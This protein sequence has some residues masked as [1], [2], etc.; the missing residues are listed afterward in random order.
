MHYWRTD[1]FDKLSDLQS[2]LAREEALHFYREY[3]RFL[4]QGLR[5]L[6]L[7]QIEPLLGKL[8]SLPES[9][10]RS[11]ASLLLHA[12][13]HEP[14]HRLLPH[15]LYEGFVRPVLDRWKVELPNDPEPL[16]WT[17]SIDDLAR[18]LSLEPECD[19]T[20]RKLILRILEFVGFSTHELPD[21]Y[22]GDVAEDLDLIALARREAGL[23][24]DTEIRAK[25][26][27]MIEEEA[28]EIATYLG[29]QQ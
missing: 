4:E 20:R 3:L 23:F 16:R 18:A 15:P 1:S 11:L 5:P 21:G 29:P 22:L 6:A 12:C 28:S 8:H 10:Q 14:G 13:E 27:K 17:A 25:Y 26:L 19:Y 24:L 2:A 7:R 9:E